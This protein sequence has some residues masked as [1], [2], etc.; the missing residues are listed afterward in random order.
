MP[1]ALPPVCRLRVRRVA[2]TAVCER[3]AALVAAV[4][5]FRPIVAA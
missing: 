5:P 3:D 1:D 4:E 2:S